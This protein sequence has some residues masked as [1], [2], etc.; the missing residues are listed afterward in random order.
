MSGNGFLG[1]RRFGLG[2]LTFVK[3]YS[4]CCSF[5]VSE[6]NG[7][8]PPELKTQTLCDYS[9]LLRSLTSRLR[10]VPVLKCFCAKAFSGLSPSSFFTFHR[11][12]FRLSRRFTERNPV[13]WTSRDLEL[14]VANIAEIPSN[15]FGFN[16]VL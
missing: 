5:L 4:V 9:L 15:N 3:G 7:K 10:L 14:Q 13:F 2:V 16:R 6:I 12:S 8:N 1:S 11:C